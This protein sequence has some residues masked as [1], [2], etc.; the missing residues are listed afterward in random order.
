MLEALW[1]SRESG[2]R[3]RMIVAARDPGRDARRGPGALVGTRRGGVARDG[4]RRCGAGERHPHPRD[5]GAP[6]VMRVDLVDGAGVAH[7]VFSGGDATADYGWLRSPSTRRRTGS[8]RR[9]STRSPGGR[10]TRRGSKRSGSTCRHRR[11]THTTASTSSSRLSAS[12]GALGLGVCDRAFRVV[13]LKMWTGWRE[14]LA[15]LKGT[16]RSRPLESGNRQRERHGR[17]VR[18]A[19]TGVGRVSQKPRARGPSGSRARGML[20]G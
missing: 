19:A 5:L 11:R 7:T 3:V 4:I 6:C 18:D 8:R 10:A 2:R 20:S 15:I 9:R 12:E 17:R 1:N 16:G 13:L 14:A